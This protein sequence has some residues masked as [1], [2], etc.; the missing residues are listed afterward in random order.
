M[1]DEKLVIH[2]KRAKGEDGYKIFSVR[3]K[4]ELVE[5]MNNISAQ[6]GFS[7]NELISRFLEFAIE[8]CIIEEK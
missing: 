3:L 2:P 8:H 6:T 5:N 7:R 4:E 1:H